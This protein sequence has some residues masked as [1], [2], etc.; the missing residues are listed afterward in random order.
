MLLLPEWEANYGLLVTWRTVTWRRTLRHTDSLT[1][2]TPTYTETPETYLHTESGP[3]REIYLHRREPLYP[4][5]T[6]R[7]KISRTTLPVY[8]WV[9]ESEIPGRGRGVNQGGGGGGAEG[10]VCP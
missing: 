10:G 3:Q 2:D 9:E 1:R 8:R 6:H 7:G 4:T 5:P